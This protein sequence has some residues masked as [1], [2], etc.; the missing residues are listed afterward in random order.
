MNTRAAT[1]HA[2]IITNV[3]K[4][5]KHHAILRHWTAVTFFFILFL[6]ISIKAPLPILLFLF[7]MFISSCHIYY[8]DDRSAKKSD[9]TRLETLMAENSTIKQYVDNIHNQFARDITVCEYEVLEKYNI[10]TNE[11]M[12]YQRL[13]KV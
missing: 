4:I 13:R 9:Y 10:Q 3:A 12:S 7:F 2:E 1:S 6:F 11:N 5:K 8:T